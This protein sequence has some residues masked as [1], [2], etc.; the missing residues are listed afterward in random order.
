MDESIVCCTDLQEAYAVTFFNP[1]PGQEEWLAYGTDFETVSAGA[2]EIRFW[3]VRY[4][5]FCGERLPDATA[6]PARNRPPA[7]A[8]DA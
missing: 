1:V 5:P 3:P 8:G 6:F 4:C 7:A 2:P